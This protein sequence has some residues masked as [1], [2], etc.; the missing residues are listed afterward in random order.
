[1]L[2]KKGGLCEQRGL[3]YAG[4]LEK[5]V[6]N[7][8]SRSQKEQ[9]FSAKWTEKELKTQRKIIDNEAGHC[10]T[11]ECCQKRARARERIPQR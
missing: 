7:F 2:P 8:G 3:C 5:F 10:K 11:E 9:N 6:G 4:H 1:M